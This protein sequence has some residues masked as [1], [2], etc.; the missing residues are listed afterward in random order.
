MKGGGGL[1][2]LPNTKCTHTAG[3][4]FTDRNQRVEKKTLL[5]QRAEKPDPPTLCG[6]R[7]CFDQTD[8]T[9]RRQ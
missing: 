2:R 3:C 9:Q 8:K 6:V 1:A 7:E 4:V 5:A